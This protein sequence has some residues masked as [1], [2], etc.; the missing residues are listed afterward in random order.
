MLDL[1][2]NLSKSKLFG[3]NLDS[4]FLQADASFLSCGFGLM[5]FVFLAFLLVLIL[6]DTILG[7]LFIQT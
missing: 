2:V 6:L 5:P 4:N 1:R 3:L 7:L